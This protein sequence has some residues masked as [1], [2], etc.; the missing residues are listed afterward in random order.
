MCTNLLLGMQAVASIFI[1]LATIGL[2]ITGIIFGALNL[3]QADSATS[4]VADRPWSALPIPLGVYVAMPAFQALLGNWSPSTWLRQL[5]CS[6]SA[7]LFVLTVSTVSVLFIPAA[8]I[9]SALQQ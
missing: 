2:A 8:T 7:E 1:C 5:V 6:G 9:Y 4:L 3:L